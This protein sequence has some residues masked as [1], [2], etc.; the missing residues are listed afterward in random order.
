MLSQNKKNKVLYSHTKINSFDVITKKHNMKKLISAS[1]LIGLS[2]ASCNKNK[3]TKTCPANNPNNQFEY[4][5]VNNSN[6]RTDGIQPV[7]LYS[8]DYTTRLLVAKGLSLDHAASLTVN[9]S[10]QPLFLYSTNLIKVNPAPNTIYTLFMFTSNDNVTTTPLLSETLTNA[11]NSKTIKCTS[12]I[13]DAVIGT[14]TLDSKNH[15]TSINGNPP[16]IQTDPGTTPPSCPDKTSNFKECFVCSWNELNND[17]LGIIACVANP[18]SCIIACGIACAAFHT[19][20]HTVG[21]DRY[22]ELANSVD[23]LIAVGKY[24]GKSTFVYNTNKFIFLY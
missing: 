18:Q 4:S 20:P 3:E 13:N 15:I 14:V 10:Q 9:N 7:D 12:L 1:L 22:T 23:G 6:K 16:A 24:T 19:V 2:L 8:N 17:M 5:T 21:S 11:D